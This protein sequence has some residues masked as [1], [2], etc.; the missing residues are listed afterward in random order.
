MPGDNDEPARTLSLSP[1]PRVHDACERFEAEWRSGRRPDIEA[2]LA[3]S[4][5]RDRRELF[6]ELLAVE[7]EIREGL[8]EEPTA[9]EYHERFPEWSREITQAF[10]DDATAAY[11]PPCAET[12]FDGGRDLSDLAT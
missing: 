11:R 12:E 3:Q 1:G 7:R 10:G 4:S 2:T 6:I 8:G 9:Y 5:N